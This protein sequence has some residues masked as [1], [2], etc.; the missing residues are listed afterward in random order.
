MRSKWIACLVII[1]APLLLLAPTVFGDRSYVPFDLAQYPPQGTTL[2]AAQLD[3]IRS[4][5][6]N[7][8]ISELPVTVIPEL[9]LAGEEFRAGRLPLWNPYARF[10]GPLLGN[11]LDG[12]LYPPNAILLLSAD[13]ASKLGLLAWLAFS[14]AGL[15]MYGLLRE[16]DMSASASLLGALVFALGGTL[17]ANAPF[18]MRLNALIW[19]PGMMHACLLIARQRG[20]DRIPAAS[21]LSIC[22]G[23][24][25][26][27]GFP[28]YAL[29][30][31]LL[32]AGWALLHPIRIAAQRDLRDGLR[33]TSW[34]I[35]AGMVGLALSAVQLLPNLEYSLA[36]FRGQ[37]QSGNS[38]AS[39]G[40]DPAGLLGLLMPTLFGDP[41]LGS[42][43]T[44]DRSPLVH[45]L[46]SRSSWNET[47]NSAG[48]SIPAGTPFFPQR[49]NF[50]EYSIFIGALPLLLAVL[51]AVR[52]TPMRGA[53]L[54]L[55][56]LFMAIACA[57]AWLAWVYTLPG[58]NTIAP[59]RYIAALAPLLAILAAAGLQSLEDD[60]LRRS[61]AMPACSLIL[62]GLAF[63]L[64]AWAA[65]EPPL[66]ERSDQITQIAERYSGRMP[67]AELASIRPIAEARF[68]DQLAAANDRLVEN[69]A[70]AGW[71][72]L[73][74]GILLAAWPLTRRHLQL[75]PLLLGLTILLCLTEL[76]VYAMPLNAGRVLHRR[77]PSA[78]NEFLREQRDA[79]RTS[80][81]FSIARASP[82]GLGI[83]LDLPIGELYR[84]RIRDLNAYSFV[85]AWSQEVFAR[86][87]GAEVLRSGVWPM[88]LPDSPA[89]NRSALDLLGLRFLLSSHKLEHA[90]QRVGPELEGPG[91]KAFYIYEREDPLPRAFVVPTMRVMSDDA[92]VL[93]AM[94]PD[95]A[96]EPEFDPHA[97]VLLTT[98]EASRLPEFS[99]NGE[100]PFGPPRRVTFLRDQPQDILLSISA[101]RPG[102]LV[103][104][105]AALP[106]WQATCNGEP[107]S[108]ARGNLFMRVLPLN[109]EAV[110][111]RYKYQA[112]GLGRGLLIST[113]AVLVLI[114]GTWNCLHSRRRRNRVEINH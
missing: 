59:Q 107:S 68:A 104:A 97:E 87:F 102:Y 86:L 80:G 113:A 9:E 1:L 32:L 85:D 89:L 8:D 35:A 42:L 44:Y 99:T 61:W 72:L 60:S 26:L 21:A 69:L 25:W 100:E 84:E 103:L 38:L 94:V 36:S 33:L 74:A 48:L 11:G 82:G 22:V 52:R 20:R 6:A 51:G 114:A 96:H 54:A 79:L 58:L 29:L 45:L 92:Q 57:P 50:T 108:F 14:I 56:L 95:L 16:L 40:F 83:P 53:V 73:L 27:A 101:G 88:T 112:P 31:S 76:L 7:M 93:A 66:H 41:A 43:P 24:S 109:G 12:L 65:G 77:D 98:R 34:I 30:A 47:I 75:R 5:P 2:D 17:S 46:F 15:L 13:P 106:G 49:Y 91:G 71:A 4:Q 67:G 37:A 110:E 70:A 78:V 111:V 63:W 23:M 28:P 55:S 105:D 18:Y 19:L 81:G 3:A 64:S 62:A 10:G 39:Q 90:G